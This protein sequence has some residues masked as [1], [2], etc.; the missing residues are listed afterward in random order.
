MTHP[1]PFQVLADTVLAL[2]LALVL[3]VVA[4]LVLVVAGNFRRWKWANKLWFRLAHL[5]AI[6]VVVAESW[7]GVVCPLTRLEMW[8]RAQGGAGRYGGGF[9][10][11]WLA[12]LLYYDAPAW[13]FTSTY[14]L[15]GVS[16]AASWWYF[17]PA[18]RNPPASSRRRSSRR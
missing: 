1:L 5:A 14:T 9:I 8:L 11:H 7:F 10:E 15:F 16:V 3:F 6:A 18:P 2:H 17:P 12:R 4:G 13:V